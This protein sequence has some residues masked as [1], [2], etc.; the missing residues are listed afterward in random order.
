MACIKGG[1]IMTKKFLGLVLT[2]S[3]LLVTSFSSYA[4]EDE[5]YKDNSLKSLMV[6]VLESVE[7]EKEYYGLSGVDFTKVFVGEPIPAYEIIAGDLEKL[8]IIIFPIYY[9]EGM[10]SQFMAYRD[11]VV[12]EWYVQIDNSLVEQTI[13]NVGNS[14]F[15]YIYDCDG[16]YTMS[17]GNVE[18]IGLATDV[19]GETETRAEK[20]NLS[21]RGTITDFLDEKL[22]DAKVSSKRILFKLDL[23][24]S[25]RSV[26][27]LSTNATSAY[28][29]VDVIS[30]PSGTSICWAITLTSIANYIYN[31]NWNYNYFV[32]SITNGVDK[33]LA[34]NLAIG[35]FNNMF[36]AGYAVSYSIPAASEIVAQLAAGYPLFGNF[37]TTAG[38]NHAVVIRGCN[39]AANTFSVMNPNPT[40]TGYTSGTMVTSSMWRFISSYSG[41][42]YTLQNFGYKAN[43]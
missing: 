38:N 41:T 10:V 12:D 35:G 24:E 30:Q 8:D 42:F 29:N 34:T 6:N 16:V 40:T 5:L 32:Q 9:N 18:L 27:T 17:E 43:Y 25:S 1:V 21:T 2:M 15:C 28:C 31:G 37:A 22:Q 39:S 3:I 7:H 36:N 33:S 19:E 20:E 13:K 26:S 14:A 11:N 23:N 4:A